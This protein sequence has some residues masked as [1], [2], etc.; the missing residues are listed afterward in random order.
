MIRMVGIGMIVAAV[1]AL[2]FDGGD[3]AQR[4]PHVVF[5]T[6]DCEYRSEITMPMIARILEKRHGMRSSVCYAVDER[7]GQKAPKYLK[8]LDGLQS[9]QTAD[10]AV[11]FLRYRQLPAQQLQAILD[12]VHSGRPIVGLRTCTHAFRYEGGPE[13]RWN[14]SFGMDVFGQRWIRH[15]GHDTST[16]VWVALAD[17]PAMRGVSA[18]FHVR[19]WLYDVLPLRGACVPLA[20]GAAVRG[21]KAGGLRFGTPNPVAWTKSDRGTRVFFTTL[22][23]P[24]DFEEEVTRRL[25]VN[26]IYWALGREAHIPPGGTDVRLDEEYKAPPTT[27]TLPD[28]L[29]A[30]GWASPTGMLRRAERWAEPALQTPSPRGEARGPV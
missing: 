21:E 9:L 22:G 15:H 12:Y 18:E 24:K 3:K 5:V 20:L 10:V 6:G 7:T 13:A 19:S 11:L 8:N 25:L 23:H 2:P 17:H 30:V 4:K 16:D 28:P 27:Q 1:L 29:R 14:D 26:G